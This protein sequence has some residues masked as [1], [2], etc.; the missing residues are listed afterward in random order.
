MILG[1]EACMET[2]NGLASGT[3]YPTD[4]PSD[5]ATNAPKIFPKDCIINFNEPRDKVHN[6]IRGLSPHP[7]AVAEVQE[8]RLKLLR[9]H[10]ADDAPS[11]L[12]PGEFQISPDAK[13]LFVG[14]STEALEILE[15]QREGKRVMSTEEFLR[16]NAALFHHS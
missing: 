4:Q 2:L 6:F 3:L 1:A 15:I 7:G 11:T 12:A 9:S 14:T 16:G 13:R 8:H 10:I 5:L